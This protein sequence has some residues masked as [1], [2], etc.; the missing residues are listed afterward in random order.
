MAVSGVSPRWYIPEIMGGGRIIVLQ[1][2]ES[3]HH[4]NF[5]HCFHVSKKRGFNVPAR[6]FDCSFTVICYHIIEY[7]YENIIFSISVSSPYRWW[8][9]EMM[10]EFVREDK[11]NNWMCLHN[12]TFCR[13]AGPKIPKSVSSTGFT[14][15]H[16]EVNV[17]VMHNDEQQCLIVWEASV[18]FVETLLTQIFFFFQM[19]WAPRAPLRS[20]FFCQ[21]EGGIWANQSH[22][23]SESASVTFHP[24]VESLPE[25]CCT[26]WGTFC[27]IPSATHPSSKGLSWWCVWGQL[28]MMEMGFVAIHLSLT[29]L[30]YLSFF[31]RLI[32]APSFCAESG[33]FLLY[34]M[35]PRLCNLISVI[36]CSSL[37]P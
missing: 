17:N 8:N 27:T 3:H 7:W 26:R 20:N 11:C 10:N 25:A 33:K 18:L 23:S 1:L 29:L 16:V 32:R 31:P 6:W 5:L 30:R 19:L 35:F 34:L 4:F 9:K 21:R 2:D 15:F 13:S 24:H 22:D 37:Q 12:A 36:P 14:C 28:S